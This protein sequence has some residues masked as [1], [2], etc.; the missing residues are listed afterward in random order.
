MQ[1]PP[2]FF[3]GFD[4]Y[5]SEPPK[6]AAAPLLGR[7]LQAIEMILSE[8]PNHGVTEVKPMSRDDLPEEGSGSAKPEPAKPGV[9]HSPA[10]G[11]NDKPLLSTHA[12]EITFIASRGTA[13]FILNS[14]TGNQKQFLIPRMVL[15][16]NQSDKGPS[17][18]D[19]NAAVP[20]TPAPP[21]APT[22]PAPG[23]NPPTG[24]TAAPAGDVA[25]PVIIVGDEKV[26]TT[27]RV[28]I[29]DFAEITPKQP[30]AAQ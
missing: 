11:K 5:Q 14:V 4:R 15:I 17:R 24:D 23:T 7:E 21:R 6:I 9:P 2:K 18:V 3:M 26:E 1:I 20:P 8:M 29:V 25:P 27:L 28:E 30:I 10:G 16:K 19:P 13:E 22:Q 12:F